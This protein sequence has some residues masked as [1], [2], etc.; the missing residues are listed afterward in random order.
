VP[1]QALVAGRSYSIVVTDASKKA[2]FRVSAPG[3]FRRQ[4]SAAFRGTVTWSVGVAGSGWTYAS[5][6]GKT[7]RSVAFVVLG[8]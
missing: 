4:T 7:V 8:G 3:L 5:V 2:G 1:E 6:T